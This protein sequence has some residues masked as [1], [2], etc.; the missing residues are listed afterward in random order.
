MDV[1]EAEAEQNDEL[2]LGNDSLFEE[3]FSPGVGD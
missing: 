3:V 1:E 2:E